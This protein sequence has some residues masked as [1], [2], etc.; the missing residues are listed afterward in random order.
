VKS[1]TAVQ[2]FNLSPFRRRKYTPLLH[3]RDT[4]QSRINLRADR[5]A[6]TALAV[7]ITK[8][9][10]PFPSRAEQRGGVAVGLSFRW[11]IYV[12][13]N[14]SVSLSLSLCCWQDFYHCHCSELQDRMMEGAGPE[15][16]CKIRTRK[17]PSQRLTIAGAPTQAMRLR[18]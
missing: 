17:R 12:N 3:C 16:C 1:K 9:H 10:F 8:A 5:T 14:L 15:V 13:E 6:A 18:E 11:G 7:I 4:I 2:T